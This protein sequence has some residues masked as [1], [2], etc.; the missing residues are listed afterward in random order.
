V[1]EKLGQEAAMILG[2]IVVAVVGVGLGFVAVAVAEVDGV[3]E[4]HVTRQCYSSL[5][6]QLGLQV[7]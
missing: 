2:R 6:R 3:E 4:E 5:T 7:V 1:K